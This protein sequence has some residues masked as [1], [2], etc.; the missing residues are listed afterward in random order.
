MIKCH[1]SKIMGEKR[2]KLPMLPERQDSTEAQLRACTT[3]LRLE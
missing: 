1:L 3:K 2:L